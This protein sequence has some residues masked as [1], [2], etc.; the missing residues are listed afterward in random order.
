MRLR[1]CFRRLSTNTIL[2]MAVATFMTILCITYHTKLTKKFTKFYD[3]R[4]FRQLWSLLK[5][6]CRYLLFSLCMIS[7]FWKAPPQQ[8]DLAQSPQS[9]EDITT[10][11]TQPKNFKALVLQYTDSILNHFLQ[12]T[13][14]AFWPRRVTTH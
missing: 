12:I 3:K 8:Q 5:L 9:S 6:M 14:T 10:S 2:M 1:Q 13:F 7:Y 11:S 4:S